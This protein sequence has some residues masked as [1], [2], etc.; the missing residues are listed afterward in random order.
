MIFGQFACLI[1]AGLVK[2]QL[3]WRELMSF[4]GSIFSYRIFTTYFGRPI[5]LACFHAL[6]LYQRYQ[7][8]ILSWLCYLHHLRFRIWKWLPLRIKMRRSVLLLFIGVA[9]LVVNCKW[10]ET[11]FHCY[12][13]SIPISRWYIRSRLEMSIFC[14]DQS[15]SYHFNEKPEAKQ[16]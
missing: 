13:T 8:L 9:V 11:T 15:P 3:I 12:F 10:F 14:Q 6:P 16:T 7:F 2:I 4:D 1:S 5:W